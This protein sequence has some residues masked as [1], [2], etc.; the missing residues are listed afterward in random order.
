MNDDFSEK[1]LR[2]MLTE[3]DCDALSRSELQLLSN[4]FRHAGSDLRQA[5][6]ESS[7]EFH[8]GN[9][10]LPVAQRYDMYRAADWYKRAREMVKAAIVRK[11]NAGLPSRIEIARL[12]ES[13]DRRFIELIRRHVSDD[14]FHSTWREVCEE[15]PK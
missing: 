2:D 15:Y 12:Q 9:A 11:E 13:R 3:L 6:A 4:K 8:K 14:L 1:G 10:G 7:R 5:L